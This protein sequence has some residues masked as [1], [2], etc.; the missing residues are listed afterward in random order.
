MTEHNELAGTSHEVDRTGWPK[1]PWDDEPDRED[2]E[3]AAGLPA[4]ALRHPSGH[5][6]GYVG[7]A[8]LHPAAN[9]KE[10]VEDV[11][12]VHGG[13][14]YGPSPCAGRICHVPKP[15]EK[16]ERVWFGFDFAHC[17]DVSPGDTDDDW[18]VWVEDGRK[19][20][21]GRKAI[22]SVGEVKGVYR[23]LAYVRAECERAASQLAAMG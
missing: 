21:W 15:G 20:R 13:I 22:D 14:T 10:G 3:T 1:G 8:P 17:D 18:T 6:C 7:V 16:D 11:I 12:N 19:A 23:D 9:V 5:W 2:W 4:I